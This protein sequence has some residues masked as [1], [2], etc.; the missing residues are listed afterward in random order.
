MIVQVEWLGLAFFDTRELTQTSSP[1]LNH[2][3]FYIRS[4]LLDLPGRASL[5]KSSTASAELAKLKQDPWL[6]TFRCLPIC[7]FSL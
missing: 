1:E 6:T 4:V 5:P 7:L 3:A 2:C